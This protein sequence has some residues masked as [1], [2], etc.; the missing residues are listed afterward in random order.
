MPAGA[1]A[2]RVRPGRVPLPPLPRLQPV[3]HREQAGRVQER[4]HVR[5][6]LQEP[7]QREGNGNK[8]LLQNVSISLDSPFSEQGPYGGLQRKEPKP[9]VDTQP[10]G[11]AEAPG[12][13]ALPRLRGGERRAGRH[14]V[15]L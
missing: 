3:L 11:A 10:Q 13:L 5:R 1:Q 9:K 6:G 12:Q 8:F 2:D 14:C 4:V 7:R 15:R